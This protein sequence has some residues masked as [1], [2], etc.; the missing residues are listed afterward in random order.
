MHKKIAIIADQHFGCRNDNEIFY[1]YQE[2]FYK[3]FWAICD[4]HKID[5]ILNLGDVFDKRRNINFKTLTK[6]KEYFFQPLTERNLHM[7]TIA[8]NHDLFY[9]N[10]PS[11]SSPDLLIGNGTHLFYKEC[12]AIKNYF[13]VPWV[14]YNIS[15]VNDTAELIKSAKC[16]YLF[17]HLETAEFEIVNNPLPIKSFESYDRVFLGH[18]HNHNTIQN[19]SYVGSPIAMNWKEAT[20]KHGFYIIDIDNDKNIITN[21]EYFENT[22][23]PYLFLNYNKDLHIGN[24]DLSDKFVR[25]VFPHDEEV[26]FETYQNICKEIRQNN[27][28]QFTIQD[29]RLQKKTTKDKSV[30]IDHNS[31]KSMMDIVSDMIN[32]EETKNNTAID[33]AMLFSCLKQ[34]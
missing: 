21:E 2:K 25:L 7:T 19:V 31:K 27:P 15:S 32:D 26:S 1:K 30:Q 20:G 14:F 11:I 3:D 33:P 5:K 4:E 28:Y 24:T 13:F 6:A 34:L 22:N 16:K 9:R 12:T 18:F 23:S 17:G 10:S 8:G 29:N